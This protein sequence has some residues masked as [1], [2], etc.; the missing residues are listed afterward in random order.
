MAART[1][2][3]AR[4]C[5]RVR[6]RVCAWIKVFT[7]KSCGEPWGWKVHGWKSGVERFRIET[8]GWKV[9]VWANLFVVFMLDLTC[10]HACECLHAC[11]CVRMDQSIYSKVMQWALFWNKQGFELVLPVLTVEGILT[12]D[13]S[14]LDISTPDFSTMGASSRTAL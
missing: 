11:M 1:C 10:A 9:Q 12:P 6:A 3:C 2:M 7:V 8:L 14:T 5:V 4:A 13:F